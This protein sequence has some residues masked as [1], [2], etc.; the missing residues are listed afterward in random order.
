VNSNPEHKLN[1]GQQESWPYHYE[2]HNRR[3]ENSTEVITDCEK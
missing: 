2:L 1:T 3:H